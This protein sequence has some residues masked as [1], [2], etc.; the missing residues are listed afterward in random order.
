MPDR[1]LYVLVVGAGV[2]GLC[3]AQ[4]LKGAGVSVA[5]FER[6]RATDSRPQG[7]RLNID[8]TGSRALSDCLSP[9]LWQVLVATAGDPGPGMGVFDGVA[10]AGRSRRP[11]HVDRAIVGGVCRR[12]PHRPSTTTDRRS[13]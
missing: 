7:Y 1:S 11:E 5:V 10:A 12:A 2:G 6:D 3:L 9:D 8:P 13:R 4:G